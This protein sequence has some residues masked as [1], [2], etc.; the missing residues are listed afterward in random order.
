MLL[1]HTL[2]AVYDHFDIGASR[3]Q[4]PLI[5]VRVGLHGQGQGYGYGSS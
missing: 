3:M 5:T 4:G 2:L 1:V